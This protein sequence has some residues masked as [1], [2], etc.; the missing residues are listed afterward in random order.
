MRDSRIRLH[1]IARSRRTVTAVG[2]VLTACALVTAHGVTPVEAS[3][4][5][6]TRQQKPTTVVSIGDSFISGE[7]G[8]WQGNAATSA[9][10]NNEMNGTDRATEC[11]GQVCVSD[12][13]KIYG[14]SY[15]NPDAAPGTE[16]RKAGC[17]RSD[18]AEIIS[19]RS[20]HV[21]PINIACSGAE[22][23]HILR[24]PSG[25]KFK[26]EPPQADLLSA[27]AHESDV[28]RVQISIGGNDLAFS[29]I[30]TACAMTFIKK[31]TDYCYKSWQPELIKNLPR[32]KEKVVGAV[33]SVKA[34]LREAGNT[35]PEQ[36][37]TL[38]SYPSPLPLGGALRYHVG[39]GSFASSRWNPGGCPFYDQD[40]S[41]ARTTV[42]PEIARMIRS[43]AAET[44]VNFLDLQ[45]AFNGH[46][47]CAK[48]VRQANKGE[49][50]EN[51]IPSK[52]AE[53]MRF[54]SKGIPGG[55]GTQGEKEESL[56]PNAYGQKAL[57]DCLQKYWYLALPSQ[58]NEFRCLNTPGQGHNSM[59]VDRI[60]D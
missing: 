37:I 33:E 59:Q 14:Q 38:Q 47:V 6:T 41:W 57:G 51:P 19:A 17:H 32:V 49:N 39:A 7:G 44:G 34:T 1:A 8:R 25:R 24:S 58:R 52:D 43:A 36:V 26:G 20:G 53:W 48:G 35:R 22:T 60:N 50:R 5:H 30:I 11:E 27:I 42:V 29:N 28:A 16:E 31:V 21:K 4:G 23:Q 54:I 15:E 13:K 18:V 3:S 9:S 56:H 10:S 46:E 12:P 55:G 40:A 45:N 2:G